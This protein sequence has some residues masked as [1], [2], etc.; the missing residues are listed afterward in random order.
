MVVLRACEMYLAMAH[1]APSNGAKTQGRLACWRTPSNGLMVKNLWE[2]CGLVVQDCG[3]ACP[4][5]CHHPKPP[6][7]P[8]YTGPP[9]TMAPGIQL[10]K[11]RKAAPPA[12][13]PAIQV[14]MRMALSRT[15][16]VPHNMPAI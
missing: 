16:L 6:P 11:A 9:P 15:A 14:R 3:H 4:A 8:D 10:I 12:P 13:P 2:P 5:K 7:V 1:T